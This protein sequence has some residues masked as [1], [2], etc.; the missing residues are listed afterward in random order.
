MEIGKKLKALRQERKESQEKAAGAVGIALRHYQRIEMEEGLP[1]IEVFRAPA[2][3][4][5]VNADYLLGR[6]DVRDM[7]PPSAQREETV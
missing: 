7:L 2:D 3:H 4:F 1:G 6:T 5:E